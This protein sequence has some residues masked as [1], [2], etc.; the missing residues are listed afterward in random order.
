MSGYL[1]P[2]E[3][4]TVERLSTWL[5]KLSHPL[6]VD[7]HS[8]TA[9]ALGLMLDYARATGN[10]TFE[11]LL[12]ARARK[13][14]LND[15]SCPLAY[16]PGGDDFLSPCLAEADL[17]RRVLPPAEFN[18]WR[19]EFLRGIPGSLRQSGCRSLL[20]PIPATPSWRISTLS[21]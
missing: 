21:T 8:Q 11:S 5:P 6:R 1:Q 17:M 10:Q 16:E 19:R 7:E 15:R 2:L 18:L 20:Q 4:A 9:F 13:Y 14:Y 3:R 12:A